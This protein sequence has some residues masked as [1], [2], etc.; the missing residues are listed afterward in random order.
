VDL[1]NGEIRKFQLR[2][3]IK[4]AWAKQGAIAVSLTPQ[5]FGAYI[6][7]DIAKWKQVIETAN[8]KAQ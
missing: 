7:A 5:Q 6:T 4:D 2:P 3:D 8:I 1:L